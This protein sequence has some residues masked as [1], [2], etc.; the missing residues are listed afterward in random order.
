MTATESPATSK[1]ERRIAPRFQPAFSTVCRLYRAGVGKRPV[2]GLV[3]NLS[4]TGISMLTADDLKPGEQMAAELEAE[5]GGPVVRVD[6]RV[7]HAAQV[8]T[9]DRLI[10]ARFAEALDAAAIQSFVTPPERDA[11]RRDDV[12]D[13]WKLPKKG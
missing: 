8:P 12:L 11:T 5:S 1:A 3:W 10:G 13:G 2:A 9:G 6:L 4:E 7:V